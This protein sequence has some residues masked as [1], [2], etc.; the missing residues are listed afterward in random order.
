MNNG[1]KFAALGAIGGTAMTI[2]LVFRAAQLGWLPNSYNESVIHDYLVNHPQLLVEMSDALQA[3]Y[4][5]EQAQKQQAM[6]TKLGEA[7]FF[8]P[9]IAFVTGPAD[10][11]NTVVEFFDYNCP[12]CRA[13]VTEV[14]R[15]YREHK[16]DTRFAFI[17]Y[18]IK[19]QESEF[20]ARV[21]LAA[22]DQPDKYLDLHFSLL[23]E[24]D[25]V[26]DTTVYAMAQKAGM[27]IKKISADAAS[28]AIE[29][30]ILAARSLADLVGFNGTP[31]YIINGQVVLG[32]IKP[33]QLEKLTQKK[34]GKP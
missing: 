28:P 11:K 22:R 21:A 29:E 16:D 17:E 13:S 18:P 24:T 33:G 20:A 27:D 10:A 2:A 6:V 12:F 9:K 31:T 7:A 1:W 26:D 32:T 15:F 8:D 23:K 3:S 19:G 25:L 34:M 5:K 4:A 30:T 14:E